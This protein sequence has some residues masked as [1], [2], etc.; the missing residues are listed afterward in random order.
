MSPR[1]PEPTRAADPDGPGV[2]DPSGVAPHCRWCL[3]TR[4]PTPPA[5]SRATPRHV[6]AKFGQHSTRGER[7]DAW[8]TVELLEWGGHGAEQRLELLIHR[9]NLPPQH[10]DQLQ[11]P[12][13]ELGVVCGT[14]PF[15]RHFELRNLP[16]STPQCHD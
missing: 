14:L 1:H 3:A 9:A 10:V 16:T 2:C 7:V 6:Q 12:G 5:G 11:S 4:R 8:K 15:E 13:H